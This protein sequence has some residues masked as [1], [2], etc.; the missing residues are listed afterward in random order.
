MPAHKAS[1]GKKTPTDKLVLAAGS[2]FVAKRETSNGGTEYNANRKT[3]AANTPLTGLTA[4]NVLGRG[5]ALR[6]QRF[7]FPGLR[8]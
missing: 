2:M 3:R 7:P 8:L 1:P 4:G 5:F 6:R